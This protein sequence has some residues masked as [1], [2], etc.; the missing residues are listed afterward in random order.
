MRVN[1]LNLPYVLIIIAAIIW[2]TSFVAVRW[3]LEYLHPTI[4]AFLRF[5]LASL[6][7]LPFALKKFKNIKQLLLTKAI[8]AIGFFNSLAF[9]CQFIGQQFTTAGKSSLFV[10]FYIIIVPLVAPLFLKEKYSWKVLVSAVIGFVGVFF[11]TTNLNFQ[12]IAEGTVKGDLI[13]LGSGIGWTFYIIITKRFLDKN[14]KISVLELFFGTTLWTSLFLALV[15]PFGIVGQTIEGITAQFTWQAITAL[16]Y[17]SCFCTIGAFILYV[18]GL[19]LANAGESSILL[20]IEVLVSFTL[21]G[22]VYKEI[23]AIW[24]IVG[25]VMILFAVVLNS[26]QFKLIKRN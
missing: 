21:E 14:E 19:K 2:G 20:L 1:N 13:T 25:S 9:I 22:F 15:L 18:Y 23:P 4:F 17:L 12:Q 7:F 5:T 8:I 24:T 10:N 26:V 16:L 11:V 6:I 3:G